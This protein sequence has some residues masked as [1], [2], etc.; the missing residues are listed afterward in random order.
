MLLV[1]KAAEGGKSRGKSGK[2]R[3][4]RKGGG[5][6]RRAGLAA[7]SMLAASDAEGVL[8]QKLTAVCNIS[9]ILHE[10]LQDMVRSCGKDMDLNTMWVDRFANSTTGSGMGAG[11]TPEGLAIYGME[12]YRK[13]LAP[14]IPDP[15][16]TG[17]SNVLNYDLTDME[18]FV[19]ETR[20]T[21][22]VV[23]PG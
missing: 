9:G 2:F 10:Q 14:E 13:W 20:A 5:F 16:M 4:G 15:T 19:A 1:R 11:D 22:T 6:L 21:H 17:W 23:P 7:V 3:A 18:C 8:F 12:V